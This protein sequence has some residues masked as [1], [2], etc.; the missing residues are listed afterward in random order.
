[1]IQSPLVGINGK[2][3]KE[4]TVLGCGLHADVASEPDLRGALWWPHLPTPAIYKFPHL[5]SEE[6][7][8]TFS[9][10]LPPGLTW[11]E[12]SEGAF[13]TSG[14][15][16]AAL[17]SSHEQ[18]ARE[19]SAALV[20]TLER[21]RVNKSPDQN[22][23]ISLMQLYPPDNTVLQEEQLFSAPYLIQADLPEL[24]W[25]TRTN[26]PALLQEQ[27]METELPSEVCWWDWSHS[28]NTGVL[29]TDHALYHPTCS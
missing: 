19:A 11:A 28:K 16:T 13:S 10:L 14:E 3:S 26:Q 12:G 6:V 23:Y 20:Q 5:H 24:V 21:W 29:D 8:K 2:A 7:H 4:E 17:P 27:G 1:M 25:L 15:E 18:A 9:Y 22:G